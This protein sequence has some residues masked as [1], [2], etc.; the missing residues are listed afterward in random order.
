MKRFHAKTSV[1]LKFILGFLNKRGEI[2]E[3]LS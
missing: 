1:F 3:K 2:F